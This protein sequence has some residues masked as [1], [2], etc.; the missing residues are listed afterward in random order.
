[1]LRAQGDAKGAMLITILGG[2]VNVI[3]DPLFIFAFGLEVKG[4]AIASVL[5]RCVMLAYGYKIVARRQ[6]LI[7]S[8]FWQKYRA[9]LGSYLNITFPAVLTNL[10]T[11]IGV[12]YVTYAMAEFGDSAVA[13]NAKSAEFNKSLLQDFLLSLAL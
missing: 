8:F 6:H 4:A 12:A 2:L 13:G 3:L 11:P 9:N 1:M 10:A 7:G 5:G